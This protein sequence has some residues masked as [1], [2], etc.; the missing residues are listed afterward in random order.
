MTQPELLPTLDLVVFNETNPHG[1][2]F[3][4]QDLMQYLDNLARLLG[5]P[6]MT[7]RC[8]SL[9]APAVLRPRSASRGRASASVVPAIPVSIWPICSARFHFAAATLS[10]RL[11]MRYFT[12]VGDVG[13]QTLAA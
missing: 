1:V 8:A 3:Q 5:D 7:R 4:L 9:R 6:T 10:D 13:R 12:H 11:A 2:C